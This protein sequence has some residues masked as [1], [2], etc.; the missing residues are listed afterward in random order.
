MD[1]I[2]FSETAEK[3]SKTLDETAATLKKVRANLRKKIIFI[4]I[5]QIGNYDSKIN[6]TFYVLERPPNYQHHL[7]LVR[8]LM[9]AGGRGGC[10]V[11]V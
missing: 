1:V 2:F 3:F 6:D 9:E 5:V 4:E 8:P 7:W 11:G 10:R